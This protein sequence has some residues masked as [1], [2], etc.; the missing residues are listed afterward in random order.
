MGVLRLGSHQMRLVRFELLKRCDEVT[1]FFDDALNMFGNVS[2]MSDDISNMF[3]DA[4]NMYDN[5][6]NKIQTCL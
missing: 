5:A 1:I 2:N 4:Y 3:D 6:S